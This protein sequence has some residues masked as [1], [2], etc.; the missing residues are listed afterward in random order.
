MGMHLGLELIAASIRQLHELEH[1]AATSVSSSLGIETKNL[2]L[3]DA[4][5]VLRDSLTELQI[6]QRS[7]LVELER[8]QEL[9]DFAPD[10]YFVTNASGVITEA[11]RAAMLMLGYHPISQNLENF[12][13]PS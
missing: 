1:I 13:Y 3:E 9:F 10:G 6:N 8:Y 5:K 7:Q 2:N 11:N 4:V 12:V